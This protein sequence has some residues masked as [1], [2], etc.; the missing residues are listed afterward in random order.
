MEFSQPQPEAVHEGD[1]ERTIRI[2]K[3]IADSIDKNIQFTTDVPD[4]HPDGKMPVLDIKEYHGQ[5]S[6]VQHLFLAGL[7]E[8]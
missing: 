8:T 2:L 7:Q 5:G 1:Q 3:E 4:N 6:E